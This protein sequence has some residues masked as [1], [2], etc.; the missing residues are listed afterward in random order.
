MTIR[1][2]RISLVDEIH[3]NIHEKLVDRETIQRLV[4][5]MWKPVPYL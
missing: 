3:T 5:C 2:L 1:R 4:L